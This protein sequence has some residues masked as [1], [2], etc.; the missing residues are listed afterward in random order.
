MI[1]AY[2]EVVLMDWGIAKRTRDP[3]PLH[4]PASAAPEAHVP[5]RRGTLFETR[6]GELIGTPAYMSPE[7]ARGEAIDERSDIYSLCVMF[8][9]LLSLAHP[10]AHKRTLEEMLLAVQHEEAPHASTT[11]SPHQTPPPAELA[12]FAKK[13]L[14]KNP[15]Q[16]FQSVK[17]MLERLERR[18]EGTF[19]VQCPITFGKRVTGGMTR[20]MDRHPFLTMA[21][22]SLGA[23][24]FVAAL[25]VLVVRMI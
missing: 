21:A 20:F 12:W 4:M 5:A 6:V 10:L 15:A 9:E 8:Y 14:A 7:Q 24:G 23:L 22:M 19:P 18:A 1:G 16:R 13:G 11:S 17:E 3:S 2:G 25:V